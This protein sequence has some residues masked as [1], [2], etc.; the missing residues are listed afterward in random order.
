MGQLE[1]K[2]QDGSPVK[3]QLLNSIWATFV[4]KNHQ[5]GFRNLSNYTL[6]TRDILYEYG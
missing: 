5:M 3:Y 4:N 1:N 6:M 2:L